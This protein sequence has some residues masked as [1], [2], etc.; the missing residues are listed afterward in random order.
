MLKTP[1]DKVIAKFIRNEIKPGSR[2]VDVGC[3]TG[4]T[5]LLLANAKLS[6]RVEGVDIN[7]LKIHRANRL[8]LKA[9]RDHLV[10]CEIGTSEN[11]LSR[12]GSSTID[13]IVSVHSLHHYDD[14]VRS[15]LEM[16]EIIKP[17]GKLLLSELVPSYGQSVDDCI[18]YSGEEIGNFLRKSKFKIVSFRTEKPG[19]FLAVASK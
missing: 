16:M 2:V 1:Y 4:W 6:C 18:R 12:F 13:Y 10:H 8:F 5:A 14:V 17:K 7:T 15:L 9:K 19:V 11:L 3:G